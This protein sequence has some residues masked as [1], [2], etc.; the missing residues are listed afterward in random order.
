MKQLSCHNVT[1]TILRHLRKG[2]KVTYVKVA[3]NI[4]KN[5]IHFYLEN[6]SAEYKKLWVCRS[7][8]GQMKNAIPYG[9]MSKE[10][11][12]KVEKILAEIVHGKYTCEIVSQQYMIVTKLP[13]KIVTIEK[14]DKMEEKG[15]RYGHVYSTVQ[16]GR[17]LYLDELLD[18]SKLQHII[19]THDDNTPL[20]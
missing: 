7:V 2:N 16:L 4:V 17:Y 9:T 15:Y 1:D 6:C 18:K 19:A 14:V 3:D 5:H 12:T 11:Y 10:L 20:F 8:D 13:E